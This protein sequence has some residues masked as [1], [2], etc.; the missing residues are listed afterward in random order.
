VPG[1]RVSAMH[2]L[3]H[4]LEPW[5]QKGRA[6][7]N[8]GPHAGRQGGGHGGRLAPQL[9]KS[10]RL[11]ARLFPPR[12]HR[13]GPRTARRPRRVPNLRSGPCAR[14]P[15]DPRPCCDVRCLVTECTNRDKSIRV[16]PGEVVRAGEIA[17]TPRQPRRQEASPI[18]TK[19]GPGPQA[20]C[21]A[22]WRLGDLSSP[23]HP[24]RKEVHAFEKHSRLVLNWVN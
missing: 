17:K 7:R 12:A 19:L 10:T 23:P 16:R 3:G 9:A 6:L 13:E 22:S 1:H 4:R 5:A 21:L 20:L 24:E 18:P 2:A 8:D 14:A 11:E 15:V